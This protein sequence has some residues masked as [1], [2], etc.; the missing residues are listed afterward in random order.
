MSKLSGE[1]TL[2]AVELK[3]QS[4]YMAFQVVQ[5][6][7]I[8]TFSSGAASV[9]T[10]IINDPG[11]ATSLLAENLP[12]ASNFFISYIIVQGLG[13]AAGNL[14]NIGALATITVLSKY[15]D[16]SPRKMFKRYITLGGLG[17]G[18]LYPKF[19]NLG[20][21]AITYAIIAPLVLGFATIGFAIVYFAVRYNAL[22]V[23][24]NNVDT[25]GRA[26][27]HAL[28]QLMTGVYLGEICL[29]GLFAI[30]T[31]PGPIVLQAVF[32]AGTVIYHV[33]MRHALHPLTQH[34]PDSLE[35]DDQLA[36]FTTTDHKSYDASKVSLPPSEGPTPSPSKM[37]TRKATL[38]SR[39]FDPRKFKSHQ[40]VLKLVP[41]Y[42]PPV[43]DPEE[44][45]LAYFN[46]A[47][48]SEKPIIWIVRDEMGISRREVRG[49]REV[50]MCTDEFAH[51][52][53]KGK[54]VWEY[55]EVGESEG[56]EGV[57]TGGSLKSMP[58]WEKRVDY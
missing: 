31:A 29:L 37:H 4:W 10:Q 54:V 42:A 18:S 30:N 14:L 24:S 6:F 22:F 20:V 5:V 19:G 58:L 48:T 40:S 32:L 57:S 55:A 52:D 34:L 3:T 49:T 26:Y 9:V 45:E 15:L 13:V 25:K 35:R 27:A 46:P 2:S 38:L 33:I 17:W 28:Q 51:F 36:M 39:F 21:I 47:I 7:L 1:V 23:L 44:E 43:Y 8:T 11:S 41:D 50:A 56:L 12:K 53:G 16:K